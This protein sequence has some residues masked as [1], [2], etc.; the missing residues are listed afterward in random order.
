M[1]EGPKAARE[2]RQ[3]GASQRPDRAWSDAMSIAQLGTRTGVQA[4]S[5]LSEGSPMNP[6]VMSLMKWF[7][8]RL[9]SHD[10]QRFE[11]RMAR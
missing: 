3:R 2:F 5:L 8:A 1:N 6:R 4:A 11:G 9:D 10:Y 7:G